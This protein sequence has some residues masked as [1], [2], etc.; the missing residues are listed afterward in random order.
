MDIQDVSNDAQYAHILLAQKARLEAA[1]AREG[2]RPTDRPSRNAL[3]RDHMI[4]YQ[5]FMALKNSGSKDV[6][7]RASIVGDPYLP[8][9]VSV[10][11]LK[12]TMI[13]QLTLE[14][15]HRGSYLL[16]RLFV[17]P[18]RLTGII[19][20][21]EDE[22]GDALTFSLYQQESEDVRLAADILKKDSVLLLK[23][24]YF[25]CVG[26]GGY[27]LRVDH[28]TD[29]VW[30]SNHDPLIPSAW[31][32]AKVDSAKSGAEWKQKG[33]DEVKE[34]K[35][36]EAV[37]CYT[38]ALDTSPTSAEAEIIHNNRA[39]AHLRLKQYDAALRDTAYIADPSA[40]SEKALYRGSLAL[41]NLSHFQEA[42]KLLQILLNKYPA[43]RSGG[44]ELS[45]VKAR[46]KEQNTGVYNF[47]KMY[48]SA[49]LRPPL[50]D[51]ATYI[52]PVEVRDI[53]G[54]GRGLVTTQNVKAGDLLMCEK[55][56]SHAHAEKS[57]NL[58]IPTADIG[59]LVNLGTNRLTMGTH[60]SQLT[61]I[62]QKLTNNPS[63]AP[64]FLDLY[65]GS[66][67][68][69]IEPAIDG[70]PVVDSFLIERIVSLNVFGSSL[71]SKDAPQIS[72]QDSVFGASGVWIKAS[73]INH[74]CMKNCARTFIGDMM[75]VRATKDMPA[76]T[77]LGWCYTDPMNRE[78]M[79]KSL[80]DSWGFKCNCSLCQDDAKTPTKLKVK[81]T[82][83]LAS[84]ATSDPRDAAVE[85]ESTYISPA[86]DVPRFELFQLYSAMA[87]HFIK[88]KDNSNPLSAGIYALKALEALG[89]VIG[90]IDMKTSM[91]LRA[92]TGL[93]VKQWG[94][95][96]EQLT[97]CWELLWTV[98]RV[99]SPD[100]A[101]KAKSY[102]KLAYMMVRAGE[103]DTFDDFYSLK[104]SEEAAKDKLI[105]AFR[106][107]ELTRS[108]IS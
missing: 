96:S 87:Q 85:L 26:D 35:F 23:E 79:Q 99:T 49:K 101:E 55:A 38:A 15:H 24:P 41:Y 31:R 108:G 95:V 100:L 57:S 47:R 4:Q 34:G 2:E 72:S 63:T 84:L 98:W 83:I 11:D 65:R 102:W 86:K 20:L 59:I 44:F 97:E 54:K 56:F 78:K 17:P 107:M 88:D 67:E 29:I 81:R 22:A 3:A 60:V 66:Y 68:R 53:P 45:C 62:Y 16:L 50:V 93:V 46:L 106:A 25:K 32:P 33:N 103:S 73:Y 104:E 30:L 71:I 13:D 1:R 12:K 77:E 90:G 89:F 39:L 40:R 61:E 14:T 75:I 48:K 76:N 43:S 21:A 8:S 36:R 70:S 74:T 92:K 19:S 80:S 94:Y 37:K 6:Q 10:K 9:T 69:A 58:D 5:H 7:M 64:Q 105:E 51:C 52:G 18:V 91:S 27:G 42:L 82:G 28:P